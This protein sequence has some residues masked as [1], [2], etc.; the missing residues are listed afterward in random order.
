MAMMAWWQ[1]GIVYQV[2]PR[3]FQDS[4]GDGVGDLKG[5]TARL[6]YLVHLGVDAIWLSP[7]YPSPMADFGYDISDYCAV[8]PLFG[9]LEDFD[10]LL[11]KAHQK[12]LKLI[13]DLVPNHTAIS[14][15]WF[16]ESRATRNNPKRDWYI[17]R[18][19][20]ANGAPPN[21]WLSHFG[22]SAWTYD[23]PTGQFY[24]HAYLACQPDVNWRNPD[25]R[26]A[27]HEVMRF[28]LRRG[29]DGFRVDVMWHLI[30]DAQFRDN[31]PNPNFRPGRPAIESLH[32]IYSTDRPEVHE[33]VA[34]L[35]RV[36]D[37]FPDRVLI[38]EIYLPIER[39]VA[40]YGAHLAGAHLP[41]NFHLL[42]TPWQAQSIAALIEQY[43]AALP[44]G[45]WPNWVLGNHDRRRLVGRIG[46]ANARLAAM[47]LL[48]LKGTPTLYYGDEIGMPQVMIPEDAIHDPWGKSEPQ[49]GRD[50]CR[51]PMAWD[52]G[53][54]YGGFSRAPPWLPLH[55]DWTERNVAALAADPTSLLTLY[56]RLIALR[57]QS[58]ALQ[59][60]AY[61]NLGAKDDVL[62][63]SREAAGEK[64]VI[65]LNFADAERHFRFA[66]RNRWRVECSTGLDRDGRSEIA[67]EVILCPHEGLVLSG[68]D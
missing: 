33:V 49:M 50:P 45:A 35:R 13:V 68:H 16:A 61:A 27:I 31:P 22:G 67:A 21:N 38:G 8:D 63:F 62:S 28:W 25:L 57:R 43:E 36:V 20:A 19:G 9:T 34:G 11:A 2:Y 10:E 40:Y 30:K 48:T 58:P 18:D 32:E 41:F 66:D 39:L 26:Q 4:N 54:P 17:W 65:I 51:T 60:G 53:E 56:R 23:L 6:D 29:V 55:D 47:L 3:S 59:S 7:F 37:E 44:P 52:N 5:V 15:A 14:H 46:Q 12:G 64:F 42:E 1:T 24:Y